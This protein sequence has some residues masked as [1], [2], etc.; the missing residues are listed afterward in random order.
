MIKK[1]KK[2]PGPNKRAVKPL[3]NERW[4]LRGKKTSFFLFLESSHFHRFPC[5][6]S[7][8][9]AALLERFDA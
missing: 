9:P 6:I 8:I 1:L 2:G 3:M 7:S 5:G 4:I